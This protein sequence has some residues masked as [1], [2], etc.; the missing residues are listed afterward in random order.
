MDGYSHFI[1]VICYFTWFGAVCS[2]RIF[3]WIHGPSLDIATGE[4]GVWF[5]SFI[6]SLCSVC[7]HVLCFHYSWRLAILVSWVFGGS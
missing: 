2:W 3:A 1:S 4:I 6:L 7:M 5:C